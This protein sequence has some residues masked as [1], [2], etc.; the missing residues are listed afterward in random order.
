MLHHLESVL[1][2]TDSLVY[3]SE[4]FIADWK[5]V[6]FRAEQKFLRLWQHQNQESIL[7]KFNEIEELW[8]DHGEQQEV[9][10]K[11]L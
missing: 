11:E 5:N 6:L 10:L 9:I 3:R 1:N 4:V 7:T 2:R 8:K